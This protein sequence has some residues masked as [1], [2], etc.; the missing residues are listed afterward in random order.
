MNRPRPTNANVGV[1]RRA[2]DK[3]GTNANQLA[4]ELGRDSSYI[5]NLLNGKKKSIAAGDALKL[6]RLLQLSSGAL[7][8]TARQQDNGPRRS[9]KTFSIHVD[10]S[11]PVA[12]RL[13]RE[14]KLLGVKP[15]DLI[16]VWIGEKLRSIDVAGRS[17]DPRRSVRTSAMSSDLRE[18]ALEALDQPYQP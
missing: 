12:Q 9:T 3:I 16:K 14:A 15:D 17:S 4:K 1:L 11:P 6:E 10:L 8:D 5:Y 18:L 13:E 7:F 2:M